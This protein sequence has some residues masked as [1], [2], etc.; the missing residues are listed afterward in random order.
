[1]KYGFKQTAIVH[2]DPKPGFNYEV[3]R[4]NNGYKVLSN[5]SDFKRHDCKPRK[6]KKFSI[7][8]DDIQI[9]L[10][11]SQTKLSPVKEEKISPDARNISG[12][13]A[14]NPQSNKPEVQS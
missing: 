9:R 13:K 2:R 7:H 1:M 11:R 12:N 3:H 6:K 8:V 5:I 4:K 10:S 14:A